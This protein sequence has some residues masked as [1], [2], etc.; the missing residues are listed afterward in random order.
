M[1]LECK[2]YTYAEFSALFNTRDNQGIKRR[3]DR[4][5]IKYSTAVFGSGKNSHYGPGKIS[6]M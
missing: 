2:T 5:G 3:L 6:Q 4:W 1:M